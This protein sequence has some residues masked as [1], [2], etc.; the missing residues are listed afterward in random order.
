MCAAKTQVFILYASEDA[1]LACALERGFLSLK[2]PDNPHLVVFLDV[3]SLK[4]GA[5]LS[6]AIQSELRQSDILFIIYTERLKL[7]HSFT[8]FEV[9][10]FA[11]ERV[12]DLEENEQS[13]REIVT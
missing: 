12:H 4:H 3:H 1:L 7:S 8:G 10:V 11:N 5:D 13:D 9:G 6:S 2:A